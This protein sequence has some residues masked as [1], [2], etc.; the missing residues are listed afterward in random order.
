MRIHTDTLSAMHVI[1]ATHHADR[2]SGARVRPE[3]LEQRGSRSHT[4]AF[5]VILSS[6]G[7]LTRRRTQTNR[8][9]FSATWDQWGYFLGYVFAADPGATVPGVY[10]D[11]ADFH[12]K[13]GG[14]FTSYDG[15]TYTA[16][17][18]QED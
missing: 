10:S 6:D 9:A 12:E 13:T 8:D 5:D 2:V 17:D 4:R 18:V 3:R 14:K 1:N 15:Y 11:A 16:T 7:T